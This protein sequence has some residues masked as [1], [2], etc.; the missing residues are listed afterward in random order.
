MRFGMDFGGTNLKAGV[1]N[2]AGESIVFEQTPLRSHM[3]GDLLDNLIVY[4][5]RLTGGYDITAGGLAIKGLVDSKAGRVVEDVGEG[6]LLAGAD[7]RGA[8]RRALG[9]PFA[10]ENDARAY[11]WGEWCFG[12]GQG[13]EV[14][15]CLTLGTGV[16]GAVVTHGAPYIG[17]DPLGGIL[18]GHLTIDRNGPP[19]PCGSRGC[20]E[21]FCSATAF[22]ARVEEA[23]PELAGNIGD[24]LSLGATLPAF[25]EAVR[26]QGTTYQATLDAYL[27]DLAFGVINIIHAFGP[28]MVVLGGGVMNSAD[29]ILPGLIERVDAGA[30]TVPRGRVDIAA[31]ALGNRAASLGVAFHPSLDG[32]AESRGSEPHESLF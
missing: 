26:D 8:F 12:A 17:A 15:A 20:L 30:W 24:T 27:D 31:A 1:F 32:H 22:R 3:Q 16:G 2:E 29:C 18:G 7:L 28:D 19:C 11:A 13:T 14:M 10:V 9:V 5:L 6:N 21:L 4:A 23:H 25:F